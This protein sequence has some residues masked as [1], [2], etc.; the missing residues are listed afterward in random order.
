MAATI[1]ISQVKSS[2]LGAVTQGAV[3]LP[4]LAITGSLAVFYTV[5]MET[6][7]EEVKRSRSA[8]E[9]S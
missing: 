6:L 2:R 5:A 7:N 9:I 4:T 3:A 1:G 8:P